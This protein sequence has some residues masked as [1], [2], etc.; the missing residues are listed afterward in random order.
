MFYIFILKSFVNDSYYVGSCNNIN[1]RLNS[2]NKGLV[3]STKRYIPWKLLYKEEYKTLSKAR[4][5]ET[6]IKSWKSKIAIEKLVE[7]FKI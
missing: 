2:H 7:H 6:Q 5:R 4:K 3:K 1:K